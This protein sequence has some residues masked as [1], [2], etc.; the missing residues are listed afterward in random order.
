MA[1]DDDISDEVLFDKNKKKKSKNKK[2]INPDLLD[3]TSVATV[4]SDNAAQ[5]ETNDIINDNSDYTYDYLLSRIVSSDTELPVTRIIMPPPQLAR[6]GTKRTAVINFALISKALKR[7]EKNLHDYFT[8]ELGTTASIDSNHSLIIRGRF[9]QPQIQHVLRT[10][11]QEYVI[12]KTC[13]SPHTSLGKA[14]RLTVIKCN[15]CHSQY[16]VSTIRTGFQAQARRRTQ[17]T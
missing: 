6:I 7:Q 12:C 8:A 16:S 14:D 1:I 3:E 15:A 11:I 17:E 5:N 2:R 4:P 13:H 9:T 10:F